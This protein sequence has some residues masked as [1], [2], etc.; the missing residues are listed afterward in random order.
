MQLKA[1]WEK[2]SIGRKTT[3]LIMVFGAVI[4]FSILIM[5]AGQPEFQLLYSNLDP[6]DAGAICAKLKDDKIPYK[7]V[8]NGN[9]IQVPKD[10]IYEIRLELASQGLP[11]GGAIGFEIF[12]KIK[13]GMSEFVQNVN[14]QRAIQGELSRTISGF[15]EVESSRVHIVIPSKS[16]FIEEQEPARASVVLKLKSG[17]WLTKNQ[18]QGI[19]HLVSS[20]VSRLNP[21]NVTIVDSNGEMLAGFKDRSEAA[22]V[23]S[24][25]IKFKDKIENSMENK[26]KTMLETVLGPDKAIVRISCSLNFKR[27][28]KT[29][30]IYNPDKV[31]RS[32][33]LVSKATNEQERIPEG[34]P[35]V[36]SNV[37]L[38]AEAGKGASDSDKSYF[39]SS[40]KDRTANYEVGKITSHTVEPIGNIT[41]I[42]AAVIVDGIYELI[43]GKNGVSEW[44]Y[45]ARTQ[46]EMEAFENIVKSAVNFQADR[47]DVVEVA[48]IPF[49]SNKLKLKEGAEKVIEQ[50]WLQKIMNYLPPKKYIVSVLVFMLSY[51]FII[52]PM[53]R[54]LTS[55]PAGYSGMPVQL[56]MTVEEIERENGGAIR[57]L[58]FRDLA[59]EMITKDKNQSIES[60][61]E[62]LKEK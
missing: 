17:R 52:R 57:S 2:L 26:I 48:N 13:L 4:G 22:R 28:E 45:S 46:E 51:L 62:W 60:M 44:K 20:S 34:V 53:L 23:S 40:T 30:E 50:G 35:G 21:Q 10:R 39:Q 5:W 41:G 38:G 56:P 47:G 54:W 36:A 42:S 58:P 55:T 6:E 1:V 33:R 25:Q 19:V 9:S 43:E 12:D 61:R 7:I 59:L 11:K 37:K 31:L 24:E 15:D 18:V 27:E 8:S 3:L 29:K 16:L 32:E 14:Y 49:E